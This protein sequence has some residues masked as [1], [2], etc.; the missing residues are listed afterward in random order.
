MGAARED[1]LAGELQRYDLVI[2]GGRVVDPANAVDGAYQVA[3]KDGLVAAVAKELSPHVAVR[4]LDAAGAVVAPGIIDMHVHNFQWV[5]GHAL[6]PDELG[7]HSGVTNLADVTLMAERMHAVGWTK[8]EIAGEIEN[9]LDF[10]F[11]EKATGKTKA[12]LSRW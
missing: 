10:R 8:R 5:T 1:C 3:I 9:N 4:T 2:K 12:E 7:V 11:L 6:N